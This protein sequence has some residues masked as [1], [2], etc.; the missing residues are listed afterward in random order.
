MPG[1]WIHTLLL[2]SILGL[3]SFFGLG[4]LYAE[5]S[6]RFVAQ[7][8]VSFAP[9]ET[10]KQSGVSR[11]QS[12][13]HGFREALTSAQPLPSPSSNARPAS[14]PSGHAAVVTADHKEKET[15]E[16]RQVAVAEPLPSKPVKQNV[17]VANIDVEEKN[18]EKDSDEVDGSMSDAMLDK[19]IGF[20]SKENPSTGKS[21]GKLERPQ[22]SNA[23]AP[24]VSIIGSLL[25]VLSAFFILMMILKKMSP[26]GNRL[27]PKEAFENLGRTFITQKLQLH[28][29]RLG[30]RLILVSVTPDGVSPVTEVT[31]PDEVVPLLG[32]CRKLDENSSTELFRKM[33]SS[34][35]EDD[36]NILLKKQRPASVKNKPKTSSLVDLYSE[37]DESLADILASGLGPKG[38][39]NG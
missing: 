8:V 30:N 27:L 19:P 16:I 9:V 22:F 39:G 34:L 28:L 29:L 7:S 13:L 6:E 3:G 36:E 12:Q 32:M 24:V 11:H 15:S 14:A 25:I 33:Y 10:D 20:G 21:G 17:P 37:P 2:S 31:D 35:A 23:I 18:V 38:A 1:H 4:S 5:D 26:K